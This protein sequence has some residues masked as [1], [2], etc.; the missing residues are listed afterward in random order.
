MDAGPQAL[1]A[2]HSSVPY[3]CV[4]GWQREEWGRQPTERKLELCWTGLPVVDS[5][6]ELEA[7]EGKRDEETRE[8]L[9][10]ESRRREFEEGGPEYVFSV[11][12]RSLAGE[13][14][15][16]GRSGRSNEAEKVARPNA[17]SL[18]G[19]KEIEEIKAAIE[20][21]CPGV[22]SCADILAL[23]ARDAVIESCLVYV[24]L[25]RKKSDSTSKKLKFCL[26]YQPAYISSI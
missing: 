6:G 11:S 9:E 24:C 19:F 21:E 18:R 3:L 26:P 5:G 12:G 22:V 8:E 17:N 7:G 25:M 14:T 13:L 2:R 15:R 16:T 20:V 10:E 4:S 23:A 1:F